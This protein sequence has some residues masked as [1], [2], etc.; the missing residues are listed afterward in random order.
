M[1]HVVGCILILALKSDFVVF[2]QLHINFSELQCN[3]VGVCTLVCTLVYTVFGKKS[4]SKPLV[5]HIIYC[6]CHFAYL[7][8]G[9]YYIF[10]THLHLS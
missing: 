1:Y 5:S 3:M 2:V 10:Q 7:T 4:T 6:I 8:K 9:F